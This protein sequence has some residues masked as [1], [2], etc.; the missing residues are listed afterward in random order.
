M[1]NRPSFGSWQAHSKGSASTV[2]MQLIGSAPKC[3]CIVGATVLF[4]NGRLTWLSSFRFSPDRSTNSK[5]ACELGIRGEILHTDIPVHHPAVVAPLPFVRYLHLGVRAAVLCTPSGWE[6]SVHCSAANWHGRD[7]CP[8]H[9]HGH[10]TVTSHDENCF[11]SSRGSRQ[12]QA[13]CKSLC[14]RNSSKFGQD[15]NAPP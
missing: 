15:K 1:W 13:D 14:Q 12:D 9:R 2:A 6:V 5:D 3:S 8:R 7:P 11:G 4:R 10:Q